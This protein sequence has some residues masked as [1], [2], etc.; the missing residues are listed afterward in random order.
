MKGPAFSLPLYFVKPISA[1][2]TK[3]PFSDNHAIWKPA[4]DLQLF[5]E[6]EEPHHK[7]ALQQSIHCKHYKNVKLPKMSTKWEKTGITA[8]QD[9][10]IQA[11]RSQAMQLLHKGK[12]SGTTNSYNIYM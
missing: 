7:L 8:L 11:K 4:D 2:S 1:L 12:A 9:K 6:K 10:R 3:Y 5:G